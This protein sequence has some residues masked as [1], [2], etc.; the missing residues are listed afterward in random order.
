M[1]IG[2][3]ELIIV[4]GVALL[5]FGGK[6]IPE[7]ARSLGQAKREFEQG[8]RDGMKGSSPFDE[9]PTP[10][11]PVVVDTTATDATADAATPVEPAPTVEDTPTTIV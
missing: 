9:A 3:W 1:D 2:P 8:T 6:K 7:L 5:L 10:A 4:L 11:E